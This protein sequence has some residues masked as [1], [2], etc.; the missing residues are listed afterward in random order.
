VAIQSFADIDAQV[1]FENGKVQ[2]GVGWENVAKVTKR[3]LDMIHYAGRL[4]DLRSPP[5]NRLEILHGDLSG[6]HSVRINDQWR[7]I[8]R[9]LEAGPSQ[10][11]IVDYH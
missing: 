1:F 5:G 9:W 11:K 3:K 8:F 4:E 6:W 7:I 10:V 2:K